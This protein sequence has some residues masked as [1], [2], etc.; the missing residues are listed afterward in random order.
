MLKGYNKTR[1]FLDFLK[2]KN[3]DTSTIL[4][5]TD[6]IFHNRFSTIKYLIKNGISFNVKDERKATPLMYSILFRNMKII[7]LLV[8]EG[9]VKLTEVDSK[10]RTCFDYAT[11]NIITGELYYNS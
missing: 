3:S 7:K 11:R 1:T 10:G 6:L 5:L 2:D 4:S 9:K 8:E